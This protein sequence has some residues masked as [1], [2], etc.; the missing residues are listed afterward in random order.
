MKSYRM[1]SLILYIP[2]DPRQ[3]PHFLASGFDCPNICAPNMSVGFHHINCPK[4]ALGTVS[5]MFLTT[6][7]SSLFCVCSHAHVYKF[8]LITTVGLTSVLA[9]HSILFYSAVIPVICST[10]IA[11]V[12]PRQPPETS[13]P[14]E[15]SHLSATG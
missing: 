5:F 14:V 13:H 12:A 3:C 1:P 7:D 9:I 11:S 6:L 4:F 2:I 15:A 10:N 8:I